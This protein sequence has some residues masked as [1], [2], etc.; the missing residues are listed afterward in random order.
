MGKEHG[1]RTLAGIGEVQI[2][3]LLTIP[4]SGSRGILNASQVAF[5]INLSTKGGAAEEYKALLI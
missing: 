5:S 3:N 2:V 4:R 1:G